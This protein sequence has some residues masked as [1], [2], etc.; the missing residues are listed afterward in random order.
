M[1]NDY[2]PEYEKYVESEFWRSNADDKLTNE[3]NNQ[4]PIEKNDFYSKLKEELKTTSDPVRKKLASIFLLCAKRH[5][6]SELDSVSIVKFYD[7]LNANSPYWSIG[8]ALVDNARVFLPKD[9]YEN[10]VNDFI[11]INKDDNFVSYVVST[12]LV[13]S[14]QSSNQDKAKQ[15]YK[16]LSENYS[17]TN[18]GAFALHTVSMRKELNVGDDIPDYNVPSLDNPKKF[19]SKQGM[20]GK[21][22]LIDFWGTWCGGC[23]AE[24]GNLH[25]VYE[26]YH[27]KGFVILSLAMDQNKNIVKEFRIK[28]WKMPWLHSFISN[29][30]EDPFF[31][32]FDVICYPKPILVDKN[33]KI[34]AIENEL[35]GDN[36]DKTLAKYFKN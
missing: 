12:E 10:L 14:I 36:L 13:N 22:Y 30:S 17:N 2:Y 29:S 3:I 8:L 25:N 11:K 26:K 1:L 4:I 33:G 9:K 24:M 21:I 23:R 19:I 28:K 35:R 7:S 18:F 16:I 5:K 34:I 20:L 31:K 32:R 15:Y 6:R 27:S